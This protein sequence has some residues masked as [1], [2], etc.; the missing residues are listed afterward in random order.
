MIERTCVAVMWVAVFGGSLCAAADRTDTV[1]SASWRQAALKLASAEAVQIRDPYRQAEIQTGVAKA[2]T[3]IGDDVAAERST[4]AALEVARNIAEPTFQGWALHEIVLVQIAAN[5][6]TGARLTAQAI[7][8]ERPL[9]A[10]QAAIAMTQLR[11]GNVEAAIATAAKIKDDG[12]AGEVLRQIVAM[13]SARGDLAAARQTLR[14]IDDDYY[15]GVAAA[16]IAATE[17]RDGALQSALATAASAPRSSRAQAYERIA[18]ELASR[19]DLPAAVT[20]SGKIEDPIDRALVQGRIASI[21][22]ERSPEQSRK[23]LADAVKA[24]EQAPD[25]RDRKAVAWARLARMQALSN[26]AGARELLTRADA[27]VAALVEDAQ[28]DQARDVVARTQIR[29]DDTQAALVNAASMTDRVAQALLVRDAIAAQA[30]SGDAAA[31]LRHPAVHVSALT[32]SAA[33]FGVIGA[34]LLRKDEIR[35]DP[36]TIAGN[37]EA[38]RNAVRKIEDIQV[39]PGAFAALAAASVT[40]D[41]RVLGGELFDEALRTAASLSQPEQ[42]GAAY[43]RVV[44]ALD[45]RL[46]FLGQPASVQ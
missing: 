2:Q 7:R 40:I 36:Q 4:R 32:E 42:R 44:N 5:D 18:A 22:V 6:L 26:R 8:S 14:Q 27:A 12:P 31:L 35:K 23:L 15:R 39:R 34:Q 20:A 25:K 33:L 21:A 38:A 9:S 28:R 19:N 1:D 41:Q 43:I 13:Q 24:L 11:G 37:L 3:L 29:I 16:D 17:V 30:D 46:L 10:S 45:D